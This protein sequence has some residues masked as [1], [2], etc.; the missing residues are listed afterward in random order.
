MEMRK[1]LFLLLWI[2]GCTNHRLEED[3]LV[4]IQIQDRNGFTE[5][6]SHPEK[7]MHYEAIDFLAAQPFKKVVRVYRKEGK[8]HSTITTYHPNGQIAQYLEAKEMRAYG[9]YKEWFSTGQ[10]KIDAS[11]IGGTADVAQGAQKDWLF[12]GLCKV[13]NEEGQIL[14][15]IPYEN[16]S[17]QGTCVYFYPSGETQKTIPYAK[18]ME[19]GEMIEYYPSGRVRCKTRFSKGARKG[20]SLGFFENGARSWEEQYSEGLL[21]QGTYYSPEGEPLTQVEGGRG[22]QAHFEG[23]RLSWL[24][25][26]KQGAAEGVVKKFNAK[27][28]L[29]QVYSTKCARKHGEEMNYYP[30]EERGDELK[31]KLSI[32]WETGAVHGIVK[33]WYRNGQLQSQ[34]EY[35][36]NQKSGPS[37]A[38]Y[39]NGSLMLVEE[40]EAGKIIRGAYY[41]KSQSEPTST[42]LNGNGTANLYDEEGVFLKKISY[43]KGKSL[44]PE[45]G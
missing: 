3:P 35:S 37:C 32:Q 11:I 19:E 4:G 43:I 21:L 38:W 15:K 18:N 9:A 10:I 26:I 34:R 28:E 5:T 39:R 40:Y 7:L 41:K 24:I 29:Q 8:S 16:G 17:M 36:R 14:A 22:V 12:N 42:I 44:E 13:W 6:I 31:P 2:A 23:D 1:Y 30:S 20:A 25:E 27:E 45:D 33:T